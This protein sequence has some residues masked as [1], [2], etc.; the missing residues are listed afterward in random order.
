MPPAPEENGTVGNV[1]VLVLMP[2]G[3]GNLLL[4]EILCF[5]VLISEELMGK[6]QHNNVLI[7][8]KILN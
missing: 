6:H 1:S 4:M 7:V 5:F 8:G 2:S 3:M